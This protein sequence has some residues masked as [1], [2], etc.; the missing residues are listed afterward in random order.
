MH[1]T[2]LAIRHLRN[3]ADTAF[4]PAPAIN[5]IVG[6]NASGKTS[7]LEGLHYLGLARSFRS[8]DVRTVISHGQKSLAVMARLLTDLG[9]EV[10]LGIE[11]QV[12]ENRIRYDGAS[13]NSAAELA[14]RLP[15]VLI[16]PDSQQL[17]TGGAS[18]RRRLMDWAMFHVE[19]DYYPA[20][21]RY[22]RALRQ[23]NALLRSGCRATDVHGWGIEM[24]GAAEIIDRCRRKYSERMAEAL[25]GAVD[26]LLGL[27][28]NA[29]AEYRRGWGAKE[30]LVDVLSGHFDQDRHRGHTG[31]GPHRA[32]ISFRVGDLAVDQEL[33]RGQVKLFAAALLLFQVELVKAE[34]GKTPLVLVD[35]L[36]SELDGR[37]RAVFLE[38]LASLG[39]QTFITATS[40]ELV[41]RPGGVD[42]ALF[43][44]ERGLVT[45]VV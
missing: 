39:T 25:G 16:T 26:G 18:Q 12:Q 3:L 9:R 7:L 11:K 38:K 24:A 36:P 35:D 44:V 19:P 29:S 22:Q 4:S 23:R 15:M 40:R 33:S 10:H 32:D 1:L 2:H 5:I 45:K 14:H 31:F 37:A 6:E 27:P 30:H 20:W 13:L 41:D 8:R 42:A 17:V 34:S 28:V 21:G 43:H